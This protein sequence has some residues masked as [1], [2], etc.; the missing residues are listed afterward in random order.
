MTLLRAWLREHPLVAVAAGL[1]V[2][3]AVVVAVALLYLIY[4]FL[5]GL[6]PFFNDPT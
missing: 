2:A 6:Q 5:S 4:W 3:L 1:V